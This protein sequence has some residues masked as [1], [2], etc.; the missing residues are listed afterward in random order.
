MF[1]NIPREWWGSYFIAFSESIQC[2]IKAVKY[3]STMKVF[4]FSILLK[5]LLLSR[6]YYIVLKLCEY[7]LRY[8]IK[9]IEIFLDII[10]I[11]SSH[12]L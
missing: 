6:I 5:H 11:I 7:L 4:I 2:L 8:D 9:F 12:S 10:S 1:I 3:T